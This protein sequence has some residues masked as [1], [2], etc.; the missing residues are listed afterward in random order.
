MKKILLTLLLIV[1]CSQ[2]A[3]QPLERVI[4]HYDLKPLPV[5]KFESDPKY[6]LGQ[7]LFFDNVLSGNRD[8]SCAT[9][10]LWNRGSS[11]AL[12]VS[13]GASGP[14]ITSCPTVMSAGASMYLFSPSE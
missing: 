8:V 7:A 4:K 10:H 13:I 3:D 6:L 9:C 2:E 1:G 14:E 12:P 5:R 11:D